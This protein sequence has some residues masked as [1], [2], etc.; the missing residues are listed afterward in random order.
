M[1]STN[2][3]HCALKNH[4]CAFYVRIGYNERLQLQQEREVDEL[5]TTVRGVRNALDETTE[6]V[7][8]VRTRQS[9]LTE[10]LD[11]IL[12]LLHQHQPVLSDNERRFHAEID[13]AHKAVKELHTRMAEVRVKTDE[14][15][16]LSRE[17]QLQQ[18]Q[19][20]TPS[21]QMMSDHLIK[22]HPMLEAENDSLTRLTDTLMSLQLSADDAGV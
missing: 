15:L 13:A 17:L 2:R 7:A 16:I 14:D 18:Q 5:K 10:Q 1:M 11:L 9:R 22:L 3:L 12:Q 6:V 20:R 19:Q 8:Q 21:D 4:F